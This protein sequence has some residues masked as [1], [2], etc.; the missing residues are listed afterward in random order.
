ITRNRSTLLPA[1]LIVLPIFA[2]AAWRTAYP[3]RPWQQLV[4]SDRRLRL[5]DD[6]YIADRSFRRPLDLLTQG[7]DDDGWVEEDK[8]L[9]EEI[10]ALQA[11]LRASRREAAERGLWDG[12]A[13]RASTGQIV[14][15]VRAGTSQLIQPAA[16]NMLLDHTEAIEARVERGDF[17][18]ADW[19]D[20]SDGGFAPDFDAP[21]EMFG[22]EDIEDMQQFM[23]DNPALVE[24]TQK[25]MSSLSTAEMAALNDAETPDQ[26]QFILT[27]HLNKLLGREP[28]LFAELTPE[29]VVT[30]N[31]HDLTYD[32]DLSDAEAQGYDQDALL[33]IE[34]TA[35]WEDGT[36][37]GEWEEDEDEDESE[38]ATRS[39]DLMDQF[40]QAL[41]AQGKSEST[42]ASRTGDLWLYADFLANYYDR[43]LSEG[44]YATL[45]ECMFFFYP[46]KVLNNSPRAAREMCTSFKQFYAYLR[47]EGIVSDDGF[48][49]AIW[50]RRD[51]AARVID[52]YDQLDGD[53]PQFERLF[54]HL[55]APYTA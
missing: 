55:F 34:G 20:D 25:L 51:Q 29:L 41:I 27:K 42:A 22:I 13:P 23:N 37:G 32:P 44:D 5:L 53:S 46:R 16:V 8:E 49:Q 18:D 52:L 30:P 39:N 15:D 21:D 50:R 26:V 6:M 10:N 14:F 43:S 48:A 24:A 38:A 36:P 1:D 4:T 12:M 11:E 3:G 7:E 54:A 33:S 19:D 31:G 47:A 9:L 28:E 2:Q 45:D 40:Y 35:E 17:A